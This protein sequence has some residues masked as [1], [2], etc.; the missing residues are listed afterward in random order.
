LLSTGAAPSKA[1]R[2]FT[3]YGRVAA[4]QDVPAGSFAD[5]AVATVNF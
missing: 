3:V 4:G 5:T 2:P 1:T